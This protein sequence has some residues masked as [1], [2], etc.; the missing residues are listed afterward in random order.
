M[1]WASC[2]LLKA[3]R[4]IGTCNELLLKL[5]HPQTILKSMH[6]VKFF[7]VELVQS[8]LKK[9]GGKRTRPMP[10]MSALLSELRKEGCFT[11]TFFE[12]CGVWRPASASPDKMRSTRRAKKENWEIY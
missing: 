2:L 6:S 7:D 3:R 12:P 9:Q 10:G 11:S 8:S 1:V 5:V 4:S